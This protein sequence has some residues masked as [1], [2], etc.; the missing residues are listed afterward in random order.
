MLGMNSCK[1]FI[2]QWQRHL[3]FP[4]RNTRLESDFANFAAKTQTLWAG[5]FFPP[6]MSWHNA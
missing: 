3:A 1:F 2:E 5:N 4:L 6:S